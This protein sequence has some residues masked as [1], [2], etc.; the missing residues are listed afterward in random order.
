[1]ISG[2]GEKVYIIPCKWMANLVK[3]ISQAAHN[4][5]SGPGKISVAPLLQKEDDALG[6]AAESL[7]L[8]SG[9]ASAADPAGIHRIFHLRHH[10]WMIDQRGGRGGRK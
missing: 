1:M 3:Y 10:Q 5:S 2:N 6:S 9:S 8:A 4:S 7:A